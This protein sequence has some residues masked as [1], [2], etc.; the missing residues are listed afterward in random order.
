MAVR[1]DQQ[2]WA[3][4]HARLNTAA[5]Q[6][7]NA[8]RAREQVEQALNTIRANM[9]A[10]AATGAMA[11]TETFA[12]DGGTIVVF[13]SEDERIAWALRAAFPP[14]GIVPTGMVWK[15][16]RRKL[17]ARGVN[18]SRPTYFRALKLNRAH[19]ADTTTGQSQG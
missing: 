11:A 17:K 9:E 3:E 6:D 15:E 14:H 2:W 12:I 8:L 7:P 16:V 13:S 18:T 19:L 10:S 5:E 4:I 1:L